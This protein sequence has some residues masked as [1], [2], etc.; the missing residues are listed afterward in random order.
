MCP[1][2]TGFGLNEIAPSRH[3][4]LPAPGQP[5]FENEQFRKVPRSIMLA[6]STSMVGTRLSHY[7]IGEQLGEGGMGAVYRAVDTRLNRTVAVKVLAAE[8][9]ADPARRQRFSREA[10]AASSLNH[11]NRDHPR[12]RRCGWRRFPR[13]G[14]DSPHSSPHS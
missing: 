8:A 6:L 10:R 14:E 1:G 7:A 3:A 2:A 11:P 5:V 13:D 4:R 9:V 12:C